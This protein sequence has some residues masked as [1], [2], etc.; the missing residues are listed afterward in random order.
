[1][2]GKIFLPGKTECI[3][4]IILSKKEANKMN[5]ISL[6][7]LVSIM[8]SC[9]MM[10]RTH[11]TGTMSSDNMRDPSSIDN[12]A[13]LGQ[14][15]MRTTAVYHT[16]RKNFVGEVLS[17]DDVGRMIE[18]RDESTGSIDLYNPQNLLLDHGCMRGGTICVDDI[19]YQHGRWGR[20]EAVNS[21]ENLQQPSPNAV[22][23]RFTKDG[24]P[25]ALQ[26]YSVRAV[27]KM[28]QDAQA[29]RK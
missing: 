1:M 28:K 29:N 12:E 25:G 4:G 15:F 9:S 3:R 18:I 22:G 19:V 27:M 23:V 10:Q 5:I 6:F 14:A 26:L 13:M 2:L 21:F 16:D 11:T 8:T 17:V 7:I 24:A 20:V